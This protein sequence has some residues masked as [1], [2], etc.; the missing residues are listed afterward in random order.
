[1]IVVLGEVSGAI[2]LL[3]EKDASRTEQLSLT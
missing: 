3:S 1:M 2:S